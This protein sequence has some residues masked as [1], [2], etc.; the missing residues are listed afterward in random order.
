MLKKLINLLL[1]AIIAE[2]F[3][4]AMALL[5]V[6]WVQGWLI[7]G[8]CFIAILIIQGERRKEKQW[9]EF[10]RWVDSCHR[11]ATASDADH[12]D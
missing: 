1:I 6:P 12:E 7:L 4:I 5:D 3:G 10:M 11:R 8:L 9:D 2:L